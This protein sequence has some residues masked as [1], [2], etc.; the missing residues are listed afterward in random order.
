LP[1]EVPGDTAGLAG[2]P[3]NDLDQFIF[4]PGGNGGE[5]RFDRRGQTAP[6]ALTPLLTSNSRRSLRAAQLPRLQDRKL[7]ALDQE[8][9]G[10]PS[11]LAGIAAAMRQVA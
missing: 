6:R 8:F 3:R 2:Q 9:C 11:L 5:P 4:L 10:L 1:I 7:V